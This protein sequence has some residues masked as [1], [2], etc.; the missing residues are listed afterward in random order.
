M[1]PLIGAALGF[2]AGLLLLAIA[3]QMA[4]R[5]IFGQPELSV[6]FVACGAMGAWILPKWYAEYS[7]SRR[8]R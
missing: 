2:V 1:N 4:G 7:R 8:R 6:F 3:S 5:A